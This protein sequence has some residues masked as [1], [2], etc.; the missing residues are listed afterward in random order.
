MQWPKK[1][2]KMANSGQQ[3]T[4]QKNQDLAT[5]NRV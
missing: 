4:A 2:D 5:Y 3:K 1:K